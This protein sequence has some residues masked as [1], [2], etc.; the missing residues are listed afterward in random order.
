MYCHRETP[1]LTQVK[2]R[3]HDSESGV[4]VVAYQG[5]PGSL[6]CNYPSNATPE[7]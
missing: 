7:P 6:S 4:L 2:A 5:V 1:F 3:L